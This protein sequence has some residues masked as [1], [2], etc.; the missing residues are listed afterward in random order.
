[1]RTKR[2]VII[3]VNSKISFLVILAFPI[4]LYLTPIDW[5]N[6]QHTICLL[7]NI[8]GIDCYGCGITRAVLSGIQLDFEGAIN[9]NKMVVIVLPLLIYTW[10][11]TTTS[12]Y[13]K[14]RSSIT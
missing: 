7:K 12:F 1:M 3:K 5:L 14:N 13:K 4:L 10:I 8:F 2:N 6:K 9:Y 11:K